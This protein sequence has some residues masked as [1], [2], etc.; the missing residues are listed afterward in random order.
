MNKDLTLVIM[1]AG[2]GSRFGGLKQIEPF[3]PNKEF[4]IDYSIYD[5]IQTGFK[6]VVF[7][8]KEENFDIFKT[9]IGSRIK[10]FINIEYVFQK[11]D[12]IDDKYKIKYRNKPLG[13]AFAILCAKNYVKGNF[14]V[15]NSDDFYG[16]DAFR[17]AAEFLRNIDEKSTNYALVVYNAKNTLT[18]NGIV[19]RGVTIIK[20][21][22]LQTIIESSV[23]QVGNKIVAT[24]LN[25]QEAF[26]LTDES[27][28]SVNMFAFTPT[29]F[30]FLE[31]NLIEFLEKNKDNYEECEYLM[32]DVLDILIKQKKSSI[33]ILPTIAKWYGVTYKEDS[34]FVKNTLKK[35]ISEKKY[36][37]NLWEKK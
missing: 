17:V 28:V 9:T 19:K 35:L 18:E 13:T 20:D 10:D 3:G 37:S 14:L 23:E 27:I 6:K 21:N 2:M 12:V 5:A 29:I 32:P 36:P 15:I 7:I 25:G 8:I 11:N 16:R 34:A 22:Y 31:D 30:N 4:L 24:P 26:S 33:K 1:A